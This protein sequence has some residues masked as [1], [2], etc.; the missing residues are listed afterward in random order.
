MMIIVANNIVLSQAVRVADSFF[1]RLKGLLGTKS[2]PKGQALLIR[3]CNS[4]HTFGMR[5]SID[6]LFISK[7]GQI[8][9][10][11]AA[12]PPGRMAWCRGGA[13]VIEL[14]A[15]TVDE[16]KIQV[17]KCLLIK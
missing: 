5:Y 2:L 6:V 3:P 11:I 15:G 1:T 8:L 13:F 16:S 4:V 10:I 14:A 17:G 7:E 12:M 9:K